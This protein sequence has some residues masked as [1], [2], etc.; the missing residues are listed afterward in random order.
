M[1][2]MAGLFGAL[3]MLPARAEEEIN[4]AKMAAMKIILR[5]DIIL[6]FSAD[7]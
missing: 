5:K 6:S 2:G 4:R 1:L 7:V 3:L